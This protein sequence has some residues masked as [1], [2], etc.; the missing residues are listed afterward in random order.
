MIM[1]EPRRF[2]RAN[3]RP[4]HQREGGR[5]SH[6]EDV[7]IVLFPG[8]LGLAKPDSVLGF[9][10]ISKSGYSLSHRKHKEVIISN[11]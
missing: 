10:G 1:D 5:K 2:S 9:Y 6:R 7:S 4:S 3:N 11:G 8:D